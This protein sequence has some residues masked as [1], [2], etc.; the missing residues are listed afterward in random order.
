MGIHFKDYEKIKRVCNHE[1]GHY[2]VAR[3]L[4]FKTPGINA[5]FNREGGLKGE[6][7][8]ELWTPGIK[9]LDDLKM[10]IERRVQVLLAG[11]M[12][13]SINADLSCDPKYAFNEWVNGGS[14]NDHAKIRELIQ[15]LRNIKHPETF[16][17]DP[18]N[19]ELKLI[20]DELFSGAS[21]IINERI[22]LIFEVGD[23]LFNKVKDYD[24]TYEV[25]ESEINQIKGIQDLY[26]K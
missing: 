20:D 17:A 12:A 16:D 3:E 23:L 1:A 2:I 21:K 26:L 4:N 7:T 10:Y 11:A 25:S 5:I 13:E 19:A 15:T 18:I 6:S 8:I 14:M 24:V 22:D 9:T